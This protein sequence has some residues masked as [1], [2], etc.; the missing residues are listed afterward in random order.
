MMI[1]K[2]GEVFNQRMKILILI[3]DTQIKILL[4]SIKQS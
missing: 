2:I 1:E 4:K 3:I